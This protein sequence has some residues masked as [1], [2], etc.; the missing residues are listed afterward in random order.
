MKKLTLSL[1][2]V[3]A[4]FMIGARVPADAQTNATPQQLQAMIASGQEQAALADLQAV[5]QAHPDSGV[6]W[7]LSAEAQDAAGNEQAARTA[8]AN[9]EHY[10]P[11]LP[12]AQPNEV[13]ALQ[14]HLNGT[15]VH[16]GHGISPILVIVGMVV[17]FLVLR[18]LFRRR[19][20]APMGYQ[21]GYGPVGPG[22]PFPYGGQG[23]GMGIGGSLLGGLAAGAGFAAGERII[24]GMMGGNNVIDPAFGSDTGPVADRDDGLTGS[25]DWDAGD[26]NSNNDGFDPGNSW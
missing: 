16:T 26:Q 6:A 22:G 15:V 3:F 18:M 7:Y 9:A 1:L 5:L 19:Y 21:G 8:L 13:A 2:A 23:P 10:A 25:P 14:A 11:G 4:G 24:D 17:L 12:F 20:V